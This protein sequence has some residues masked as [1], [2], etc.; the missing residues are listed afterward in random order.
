M[1]V[2]P[3]LKPGRD[4]AYPEYGAVYPPERGFSV[5]HLKLELWID[6]RSRRIRG[7]EE[8]RLARPD[9]GEGWVK[10]D[11]SEL[12]VL[13][14]TTDGATASGTTTASSSRSG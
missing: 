3:Y 11:A 9:G 7:I 2:H 4:F 8:L 1:K 5:R 6:F 14:V 13:S 12:E 10:L